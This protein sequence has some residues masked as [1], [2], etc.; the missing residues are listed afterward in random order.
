MEIFPVRRAV[1]TALAASLSVV[2][3]AAC[4][5]D[6]DEPQG[7]AASGTASGTTDPDEPLTAKDACAAM[8]IEGDPPLERAV[9]DALVGVSEGLDQDGAAEMTTVGIR[10][11]SLSTKVPAE[12]DDAVAQVRVPFLQLQTALDAGT[13]QSVDL[14]VASA[15]EGLVAYRALCED[16]GYAFD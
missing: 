15:R 14:D 5:P 16:E 4:S 3:L 2:L 9:G 13:E 11:G 1:A 7:P 12:F 8:Y 10:L 6:D